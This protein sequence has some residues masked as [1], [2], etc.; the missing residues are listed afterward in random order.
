MAL[1]SESG[2]T[3]GERC[4][5]VVGNADYL[6]DYCALGEI[7]PCFGP[8]CAM[9]AAC[10]G[11][12]PD[13]EFGSCSAFWECDLIPAVFNRDC[14]NGFCGAS[15]CAYDP[16]A[17]GTC[18][19]DHRLF[20]WGFGPTCIRAV[21]PAGIGQPCIL[22]DVNE[23][24]GECEAGLTC[25]G[26]PADGSYGACPGGIP[27]CILIPDSWNPSCPFETEQCGGSFCAEECDGN[28]AC[29]AGFEPFDVG[30]TCYC[31]PMP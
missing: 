29:A 7:N 6:G 22:G 5:C 1:Y 4:I 30:G 28:G 3:G 27:D 19:A 10:M 15:I 9:N 14:V 21:A 18:L 17:D 20:D 11:I 26:V 24:W 25:V 2:T 16:E 13:G 8:E 12:F 31:R 23:L